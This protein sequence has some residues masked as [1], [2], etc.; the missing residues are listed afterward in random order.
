MEKAKRARKAK[1]PKQPSLRLR[2]GAPYLYPDLFEQTGGRPMRLKMRAVDHHAIGRAAL[3][4]KVSDDSVEDTH[5]GPANESV[6]KRLVGGLDCGR[7][8]PSQTISDYIDYPAN[9]APVVHAR[10]ATRPREKGVNAL[11]L[12]LS[13]PELIRHRQVLLPRLNHDVTSDGI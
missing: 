7:I 6:V 2:L 9:H 12:S 5:A 4:R 13:Q 10:N 1:T 3:G 8:P 11:K